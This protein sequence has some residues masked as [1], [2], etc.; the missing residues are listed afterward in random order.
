M[1]SSTEAKTAFCNILILCHVD[2]VGRSETEAD[3]LLQ[4]DIDIVHAK[5]DQEKD[6]TRRSEDIN[7]DL[8]MAGF[9]EGEACQGEDR[10]RSPHEQMRRRH[11]PARRRRVP[12]SST[13]K[14]RELLV[15]HYSRRIIHQNLKTARS[16]DDHHSDSNFVQHIGVDNDS[17]DEEHTWH[18]SEPGGP[19]PYTRRP[20]KSWHRKR[21]ID[22]HFGG[23]TL[24]GYYAIE[25]SNFVVLF[26]RVKIFQCLV[27]WRRILGYAWRLIVS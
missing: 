5:K 8:S 15:P 1:S 10:S 25:F 19:G 27:F 26:N 12:S 6:K 14:P 13:P 3:H 18:P 2:I 11:S 21:R 20:Q 22:F 24:L 7:N 4:E 17:L 23:S 16:L 9:D